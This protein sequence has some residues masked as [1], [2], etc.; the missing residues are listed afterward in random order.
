[1]A[2]GAILARLVVLAVLIL[3]IAAYFRFEIVT[4]GT[5]GGTVLYRLDR[6][7]GQVS[8]CVP[9]GFRLVCSPQELS[10]AVNK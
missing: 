10:Q 4:A 5:A 7:S 1:M 9:S 6:I 8:V 3:S 2:A